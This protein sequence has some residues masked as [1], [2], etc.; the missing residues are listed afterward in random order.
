MPP[1]V[2]VMPVKPKM[3]K[4]SPIINQLNRAVIGG[5]SVMISMEMREPIIVYDLNRKRSPITKP[6]NPEMESHIH[7][8]R[9]ASK[10]SNMF[11]VINEK[12]LRKIKANTSLMRLTETEPTLL[13]AD[14]NA[15]AVAVQQ[16]A[17]NN[18]AN[19][20]M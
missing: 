4:V 2:K 10:G 11:L 16:Q 17:V 18:A 1:I 5:T 15:R 3:P 7:A 14:S 20:P 19:S 9:L 13:L 12:M 6:I 8:W